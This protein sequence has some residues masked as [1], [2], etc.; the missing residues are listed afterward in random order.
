MAEMNGLAIESWHDFLVAEVGAGAALAG[1]VFVA[2]SIN[3]TKVLQ[4]RAVVGRAFEA[5]AELLSLALVGLLGLIPGQGRVALGVELMFLGAV[6]W[7]GV[8][9]VTI[10][11]PNR[12]GATVGQH[13]SRQ[14]M[15]QL[16]TVPLVVA[17]A[18]LWVGAGGG[19]Y[20]LA[21]GAIF[22]IVAGMIGAWVLLI[23]ILR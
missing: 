22:A 12:G 16:A 15:G 5:L 10:G 4:F 11:V 18:T 8:S 6:L 14:A 2:I 1:L 3:L 7:G 17:G 21:A 23:E 20:W 9:Y 19:L 13:L